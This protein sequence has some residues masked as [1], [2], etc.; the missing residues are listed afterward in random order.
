[1]IARQCRRFL[2]TFAPV[3][4]ICLSRQSHYIGNFGPGRDNDGDGSAFRIS[5]RRSKIY[6]KLGKGSARFSRRIL[7]LFRSHSGELSDKTGKHAEMP[8][9]EN[10]DECRRFWRQAILAAIIA[11]RNP[12]LLLEVS[13]IHRHFADSFL[14]RIH[15]R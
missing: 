7:D 15:L 9:S 8:V 10:G 6:C 4:T 12:S 2:G 3:A 5:F 13:E 11:V 1:M 14:L